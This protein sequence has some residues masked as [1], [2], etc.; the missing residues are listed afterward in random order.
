MAYTP[1]LDPAL[2]TTAGGNVDQ[3]YMDQMANQDKTPVATDSRLPRVALIVGPSP[4]SM[5]RGWEF[6]LTSP[7]EGVTYISTVLHNAGYPVRIIDVRYDVD[8][9]RSA[10]DQIM[11]GCDVLGIATYEDC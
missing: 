3:K 2:Y 11:E 10:Y 9:L 1:S 8:P 6:F 7:Y 5:P 4:F